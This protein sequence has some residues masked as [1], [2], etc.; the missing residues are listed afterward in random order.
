[1]TENINWK[2][3]KEKPIEL[4]DLEKDPKERVNLAKEL[5]KIT[6]KLLNKLTEWEQNHKPLYQEPQDK[7]VIS[8]E[9][10]NDLRALGYFE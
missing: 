3:S 4:Y 10:K 2:Y 1:M 9:F 8:E 6:V 7:P 5:P